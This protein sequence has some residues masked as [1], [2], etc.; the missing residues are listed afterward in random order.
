MGLM[1]EWV[2]D[3]MRGCCGMVL[4]KPCYRHTAKIREHLPLTP[5]PTRV[6]IELKTTGG[7]P[8]LFST[9][10]LQIRQNQ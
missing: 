6:G 7:L 3:E 5:H 2:V 4:K 1:R 8:F 9:Q 10:A